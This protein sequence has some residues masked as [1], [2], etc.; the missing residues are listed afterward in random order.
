MHLTTEYKYTRGKK[1]E[2]QKVIYE[3]TIRVETSTCLHQKWTDPAGSK[4][5][6]DIVELSSP[7]NEVDI[8]DIHRLLHITP[9]D[10][11]FFSSL[12]K[13]VTNIEHIL[14]HKTHLNKFTIIEIIQCLL[15]NHNGI[16]LEI[17]HKKKLENPKIHGDYTT[18]L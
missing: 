2:L 4:S 1:T 3:C 10:Y 15:S 7:I 12:H 8:T 14:G 13:I 17:N 16:K 5:V 9:A 6:K 11:T 18:H